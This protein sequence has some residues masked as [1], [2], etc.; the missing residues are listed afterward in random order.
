V[1]LRVVEL[2]KRQVRV[3]NVTP[4]LVNA[5]D[6]TLGGGIAELQKIAGLSAIATAVP[7]TVDLVFN[8]K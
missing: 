3:S 2:K 5:A 6:F 7:V 8:K 1:E 4:L